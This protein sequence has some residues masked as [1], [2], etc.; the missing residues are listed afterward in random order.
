MSQTNQ[1]DNQIARF[2][3]SK[4]EL[5]WRLAAIANTWAS[6]NGMGNTTASRPIPTVGESET[7]FWGYRPTRD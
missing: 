3:D 4:A 2:E 5:A 1:T 6:R 7:G